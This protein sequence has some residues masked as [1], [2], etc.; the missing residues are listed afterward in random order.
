MANGVKANAAEYLAEILGLIAKDDDMKVMALKA[1]EAGGWG[2]EMKQAKD[3]CT[4]AAWWAFY[5]RMDGRIQAAMEE[6]W[7]ADVAVRNA[8]PQ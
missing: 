1:G 5:G 8:H 7:Q 3:T 4:E 6:I 2:F